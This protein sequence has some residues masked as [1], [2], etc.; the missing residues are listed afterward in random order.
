MAC[1]CCYPLGSRTKGP[2]TCLRILSLAP[3]PAVGILAQ[4]PPRIDA[5]HAWSGSVDEGYG[6]YAVACDI[7][8]INPGW[9]NLN[10]FSV[11]LPAGRC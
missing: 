6:S 9:N 10:N 5:R 2:I 4:K 3:L 8:L 11:D 1:E 7:T